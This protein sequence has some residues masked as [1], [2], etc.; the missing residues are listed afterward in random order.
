MIFK[1]LEQTDLST[2]H[3]AFIE[4]FSD[5]QVNMDISFAD[6]D[7]M[8]RRRGLYLGIS[9]GAFEGTKL[10]GFSLTGLRIQHGMPIAYD[11]AT[12]IT[13]EYRRQRITSQIF[14]KEMTILRDKQVGQYL[15]E[16]IKENLPAIKLYQKQGF[17]IQRE[18]CCFQMEPIKMIPSSQQHTVEIGEVDWEQVVSFWEFEP[19]WQNAIDSILAAPE[20]FITAIA[21]SDDKMVGYGII[22]RITGDIPQFAVSPAYRRLGIGTSLLAELVSNTEAAKVRILNVEAEKNTVLKFLTALGFEHFIS[23]YEMILPL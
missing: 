13:Q 16:V 2:L 15:L 4:A 23:Q 14:Q 5:Y 7:R 8:M 6:F 12:G 18:F 10:I 11:I 3:S 17:Q 19:S 22:E 1:T 20:V 21:K 9:V